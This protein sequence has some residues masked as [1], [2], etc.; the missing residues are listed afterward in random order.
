MDRKDRSLKNTIIEDSLLT[1]ADCIFLHC[2]DVC[3]EFPLTKMS[4][5]EFESG[6]EKD[7]MRQEL[8]EAR[9]DLLKQ[10]SGSGCLLY[11]S[12]NVEF[13]V[14]RLRKDQ[15]FAM[16][17]KCRKCYEETINGCYLQCPKNLLPMRNC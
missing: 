3:S 16:S 4:F 13:R 10:V 8:R 11:A 6:R 15:N 2:L 7:K 9:N 5:I 1:S 17:V 12:Y 14:H